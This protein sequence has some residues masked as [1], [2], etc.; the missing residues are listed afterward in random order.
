MKKILN[1]K[2][3]A[4]RDFPFDFDKIKLIALD[5]DG[6]TLT[7]N[8]LTRR[9][10]ETLEEAIRRGIQ[11]V[12]ATGR[13]YAALPE[14][15]LQIRGLQY[16]VTSNGAHIS[17]AATGEFLYSNYLHPEAVDAALRIL[18]QTP[19]PVEVF[20]GG[21]AYIARTVY[22][23]LAQNGSDFMSPKYV[24]RTRIPVDDLYGLLREHRERIEN[25]NIHF[26]EQEARM[27][28]WRELEKLP[29]M[30]VTSSTRHNVE[31]GGET[32]SKASAL[33]EVCRRLDLELAQVMAFGD[34]PND[35]AMIA[36]CGFGVAMD[37]ATEDVKEAADC[38]TLSNEEEGVAYAIRRLL[39]QE[40]DG[41]A[42]TPS[43]RSRL[44]ALLHRKD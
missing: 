36:E 23:D 9:T 5:L 1:L 26:A 29:H 34:S 38:V 8:G 40:K 20:T 24:L 6:T 37:N 2:D 43:L 41:T 14:K 31:I 35:K 22:D 12:I 32:T 19:H 16:I 30:T 44:S 4:S 11:V 10:G 33:A 27:E 28:M 25:I 15:V 18:P 21:K 42:A 7:R 3:P 13:V 39:F 17:D